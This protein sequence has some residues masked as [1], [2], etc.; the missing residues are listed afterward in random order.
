MLNREEVCLRTPGMGAAPAPSPSS[1]ETFCLYLFTAAFIAENYENLRNEPKLV[2]PGQ[3]AGLGGQDAHNARAGFA[4]AVRVRGLLQ[5]SVFVRVL[6]QPNRL[7][8]RQR[9]EIRLGD[10]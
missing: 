1:P 6:Q 2:P 5:A 10:C 8:G 3:S 4:I 7:Q 9:H